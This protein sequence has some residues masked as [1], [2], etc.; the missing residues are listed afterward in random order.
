MPE[1][2]KQFLGY[3]FI[4]QKGNIYRTLRASKKRAKI[5]VSP[6]QVLACPQQGLSLNQTQ[7]IRKEN[8]IS[9]QNSKIPFSEVKKNHRYL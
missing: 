1:R 8:L 4:E 7:I 5:S 3:F 6:R 9:V 2:K